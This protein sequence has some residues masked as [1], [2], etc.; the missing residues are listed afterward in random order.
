MIAFFFG[1]SGGGEE[2]GVDDG[3]TAI[4]PSIP[5]LRSATRLVFGAVLTLAADSCEAGGEEVAAAAE[6][7]LVLL[8]RTR[9]PLEEASARTPLEGATAPTGESALALLPLLPVAPK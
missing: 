6:E 8:T 5:G 7:E 4:V 2:E 9:P 1:I 3:S